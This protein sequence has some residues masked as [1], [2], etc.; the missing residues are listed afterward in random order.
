MAEVPT[1]APNV[2]LPIE[3]DKVRVC[4]FVLKVELLPKVKVN[5][6]KA[7]APLV[8]LRESAA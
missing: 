7:N 4:P 3:A 6:A 8:L 1:P 2:I 5:P